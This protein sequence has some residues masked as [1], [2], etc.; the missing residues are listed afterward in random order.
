MTEP[1]RP[2]TRDAL[3]RLRE[4]YTAANQV[5]MNGAR[6]VLELI[7]TVDARDV[8]ADRLAGRLQQVRAAVARL[9]GHTCHEGHT[10]AAHLRLHELVVQEIR[11][12][13]DSR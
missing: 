6:R 4:R 9:D 10:D 13:L 1:I 5:G 2:L 8:E 3:E 11:D 12:A 7:A